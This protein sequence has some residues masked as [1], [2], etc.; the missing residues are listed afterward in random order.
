MRTFYE[1]LSDLSFRLWLIETYF[2]FDPVQYNQLF[3]DELAELR[4][5]APEHRQA[6]ERMRNF[7]WV[8]YIA[9]SL[10][11]TGY[12]DQRETQERT[13]DIVVKMLT[14]GLFR[15]YDE[16]QHGPLDLR[17]KRATANAI[18]NMVEKEKNRRKSI[19]TLPIGQERGDDLPDRPSAE[20][21][22][23]LIRD[24]RRL[25]RNRLGDLGLAV[26]DARLHGQETKG[27][28]GRADLGSPGRWM[29]KQ[30]VGQVKALAKEYAQ[31]RGDPAFLRDVE[32]AMEREGATI[33]KRKSS[34]AAR[35]AMR[36]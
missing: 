33:Q 8:G 17:F 25:V 12:R 16:R 23:S 19:P 5:S 2:T 13:H 21:D 15:D 4:A 14:G 26:L 35:Q 36:V 28:V 3:G 32:R 11:N 29:V 30:V 9:K 34:T 31:R 18:K 7:N 24:F 1:F 10:Q 22:E 20:N 27:L 6:I